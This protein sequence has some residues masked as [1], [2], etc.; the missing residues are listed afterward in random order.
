MVRYYVIKLLFCIVCGCSCII[1]SWCL[2]GSIANTSEVIKF[3][4]VRREKLHPMGAIS[5]QKSEVLKNG[6]ILHLI[7]F[8]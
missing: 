3:W 4:S 8:R 7:G 2:L 5:V 6:C 1:L